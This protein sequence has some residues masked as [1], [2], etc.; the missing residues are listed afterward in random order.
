[1]RFRGRGHRKRGP[2]SPRGGGGLDF[3]RAVGFFGT[4]KGPGGHSVQKKP[5]AHL[6]GNSGTSGAHKNRAPLPSSFL[7]SRAPKGAVGPWGPTGHFAN[8]GP[9]ARKGHRAQTRQKSRSRA[10][11]GGSKTSSGISPLASAPE[12]NKVAGIKAGRGANWS[13][14]KSSN[15]RG[16]KKLGAG[17]PFGGNLVEGEKASR[18]VSRSWEYKSD[19]ICLFLHSPKRW[20]NGP[21]DAARATLSY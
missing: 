9:S 17:P 11:R 13:G 19:L 21:R 10:R 4:L 18:K 16:K 15:L 20:G 8:P 14:K 5:E 3:F 12:R 2:R 1:M 7:L 6:I